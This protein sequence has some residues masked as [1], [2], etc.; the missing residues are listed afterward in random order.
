MNPAE[1]KRSSQ[2]A[3]FPTVLLAGLLILAIIAIIFVVMNNRSILKNSVNQESKIKD[4]DATNKQFKQQ[5][6]SLE[7]TASELNSKVETIT[8]QK[9]RLVASRDSVMRLLNYALLNDRNSR[10]KVAQLEK[11]LRELQGKLGDVQKMYDDLLANT[12]SSGI[13]YKQRLEALSAERDVLSKENQ[14]LKKQLAD[15]ENGGGGQVTAI[16]STSMSALPGEMANKKF[17]P[18][19]RSQNTDRVQ[20]TFS[21]SRAPKTDEQILFRIFDGTNKEVTINPGYRKELNAPANA[22]NQKVFLAFEKALDRKSSGRFSVRMYLTST[23]KGIANQEIGLA[24]F[25]LK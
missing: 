24:G 9:D 8:K 15:K 25:E 22:T 21:L 10:G 5:M 2:S 13:E 18:S 6:D 11:K 3:S 19:T 14:T 23:E 20:V 4:L 17:S 1:T 12:G 7:L 16:F